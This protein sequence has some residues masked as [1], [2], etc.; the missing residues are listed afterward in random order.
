MSC[1]N[2]T[3]LAFAAILPLAVAAVVI[4][5]ALELGLWG[6]TGLALVAGLLVTL[7]DREGFYGTTTRGRH[8]PAPRHRSAHPGNLGR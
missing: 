4:G 2:R 7:L 1:V 8:T 5:N 3:I 6:F